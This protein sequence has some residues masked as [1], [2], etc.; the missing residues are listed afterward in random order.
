VNSRGWIAGIGTRTCC[1]DS[2]SQ[3]CGA[4]NYDSGFG[5][6]KWGTFFTVS[7]FGFDFKV[8]YR[9]LLTPI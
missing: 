2:G 8:G 7:G 4:E 1:Y 6:Q 9:E 3:N 5:S